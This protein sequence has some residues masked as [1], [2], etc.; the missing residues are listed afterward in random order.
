M[1]ITACTNCGKTADAERACVECGEAVC[2]E[3]ARFDD[4]DLWCPACLD[5]AAEN[6][7]D[8]DMRGQA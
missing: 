8:M 4:G 7:V 5:A 1:I 2:I 6:E 3:C